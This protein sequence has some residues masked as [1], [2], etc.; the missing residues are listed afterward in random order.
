MLT[1]NILNVLGLVFVAY[2]V[3]LFVI[4][5]IGYLS[6]GRVESDDELEEPDD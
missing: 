3:G 6:L 2:C 1:D 5:S 4:F